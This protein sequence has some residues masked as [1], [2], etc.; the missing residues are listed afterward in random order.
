MHHSLVSL[1]S[2]APHSLTA[3]ASGAMFGGVFLILVIMLL[4]L[5]VVALMLISLWKIF[6][7][8]GKPGW[9]ALVPF[10][11]KVLLLEIAGRPL[12]WILLFFIPIVNIFIMVYTY[13]RL[14][15]AFGKQSKWF[16]AGMIFLPF[17]FYPIL[18]F[19]K[20]TYSNT[21]PPNG[22]MSEATKWAFIAALACMV[23]EVPFLLLGNSHSMHP[24]PLQIIGSSDTGY[25]TDGNYVY[26]NDAVIP[27][28]DP[29]S[30]K[31]LDNG[32]AADDYAVY[33]ADKM[34]KGADPES[35]MT[36]DN[37]Y[38]K[39]V[40]HVYDSGA[41]IPDANPMTFKALDYGYSEDANHVYYAGYNGDSIVQGAD[42]T[43]FTTITESDTA[44]TYDAKDANHR[45]S[46][47][48]VVR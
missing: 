25:S 40:D 41:V 23:M 11:N 2:A 5:G 12:W 44:T 26:Y 46:E 14:A 37:G 32:Y 27:D 4:V 20:S 34:I 47:G 31:A 38:A 15:L 9:A 18:A 1:F 22:P 6:E 39:D 24:Q 43:T 17:I 16:V 28:A 29:H 3:S 45:Y 35:F 48:Q 30:F 21:F 33:Y 7:K 8:A 10:Y 19:G 13:R 42:P 36:L